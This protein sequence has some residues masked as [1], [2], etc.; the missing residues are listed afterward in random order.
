METNQLLNQEE[1]A[2]LLQLA[3]SVIKAKA[4][5]KKFKPAWSSADS[6][7]EDLGVFVTLNKDNQLRGCIGYVEGI[8]ALQKAVQEM[9]EAAAFDDPRFPPVTSAEVDNLDIEISVLSPVKKIE[10]ISEITIGL[11]G[12]IIERGFYK[13]LLL[14]QV[15]TEYGWDTETFLEHT[16]VKAGLDKNDWKKDSATIKIFSAEIFSEVK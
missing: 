9:A 11:H 7:N 5:G 16:C 12:L 14:P 4:E 1:Q 6:L 2:F 3:R 10:D 8:M 15:A 13:G